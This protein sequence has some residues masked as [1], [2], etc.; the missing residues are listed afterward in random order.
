MRICWC[1]VKTG[2]SQIHRTNVRMLLCSL[3]D[4]RSWVQ[5]I[6]RARVSPYDRPVKLN[7][8][9]CTVRRAQLHNHLEHIKHRG[10][11]STMRLHTLS[12]FVTA[13]D[14]GDTV[15]VAP[16][17]CDIRSESNTN[18]LKHAETTCDRKPAQSRTRLLGP[19]PGVS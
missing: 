19:R 11:H 1:N 4:R 16:P 5:R 2:Q 3:L 14:A 15:E 7:L 10:N 18:T 13:N 6:P 17:F 9:L 8:R 12:H